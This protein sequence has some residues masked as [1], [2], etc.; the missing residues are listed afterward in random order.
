ME[1]SWTWRE[2]GRLDE[3]PERN[4]TDSLPQRLRRLREERG[5]S[6]RALARAAGLA[7]ATVRH[8]EAGLRRTISVD[9]ARALARAL[10]VSLTDLV[11]E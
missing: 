7:S 3:M 8:L 11:G 5:L 6:Q 1:L 4:T 10:G 2:M 9:T